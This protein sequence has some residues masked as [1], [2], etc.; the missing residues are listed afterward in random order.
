MAEDASGL[1]DEK[2]R[3]EIAFLVAQQ[4]KLEQ[5]RFWYPIIVLASAVAAGAAFARLFF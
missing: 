1:A 5:E 2:L 3:A 4:K